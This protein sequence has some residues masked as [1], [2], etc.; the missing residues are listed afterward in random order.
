MGALHVSPRERLVAAIKSRPLAEQQFLRLH[1]VDRMKPAE[2]AE[3]LGIDQAQC[4]LM[5]AKLLT[6]FGPLLATIRS[7]MPAP[8]EARMPVP[9][10]RRRFS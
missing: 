3:A 8:G 6:S 10:G 2:I 4:D 9:P 7:K 1:Y 5:H